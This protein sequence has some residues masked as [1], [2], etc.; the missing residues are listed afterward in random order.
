MNSD[1]GFFVGPPSRLSRWIVLAVG[2]GLV[3]V[4]PTSV[5]SGAEIDSVEPWWKYVQSPPPTGGGGSWW[6][7]ILILAGVVA[8]VLITQASRDK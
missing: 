3:V 1:R 8:F 4:G 7:E 5:A 6:P 2:S